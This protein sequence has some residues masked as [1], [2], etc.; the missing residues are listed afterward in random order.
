MCR[1]AYLTL[2]LNLNSY[3]NFSKNQL[4]I[5]KMKRST[6]HLE[7]AVI[8]HLL[9]IDITFYSINSSPGNDY[10]AIGAY[11]LVWILIAILLGTYGYNESRSNQ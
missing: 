5:I 8:L 2:H 9:V 6:L 7:M 3:P 4:K 10:Y 11:N 1:T